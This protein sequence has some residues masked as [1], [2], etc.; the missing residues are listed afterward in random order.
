MSFRTQ[1]A[2]QQFFARFGSQ[3]QFW[4]DTVKAQE[5]QITH[6]FAKLTEICYTIASNWWS[7]SNNLLDDI[8]ELKKLLQVAIKKLLQAN[9]VIWKKI[10][11]EANFK[12][13]LNR[14]Q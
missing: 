10:V 12:S 2:W 6:Q 3:Y 4:K 1:Q 7:K 11:W 8:A 14:V 9:A 13:L 5:F